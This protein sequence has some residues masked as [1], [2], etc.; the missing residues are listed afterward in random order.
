MG[1]VTA[2]LVSTLAFSSSAHA[3]SF[4][5]FT[6]E[7][8]FRAAAGSLSTET[9]NSFSVDTSF[10][11]GGTVNL[12]DFSLTGIGNSGAGNKIDVPPID[13]AAQFNIDGTPAIRGQTNSTVG[14]NTTF[15]SPITAFGGTFNNISD[16]GITQLR[17]GTDTVG[18]IPTSL[19]PIFF[20]F[21]A[22]GNFTTVTFASA[23]ATNDGFGADNF[24]Y[25]SDT[26]TAVPFE[27]DPSLGLGVLG[28]LW[29]VRKVFKHK[30]PKV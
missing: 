8:A 2:L 16:L 19:V 14:F 24:L 23:N 12:T 3:I 15:N 27:F 28:G 13:F 21:I 1:G 26:A 5:T 29:A 20:G 30:S 4:T 11:N 6:N 10:N 22:D 18:N 7:A 25:G 17:V 9:F